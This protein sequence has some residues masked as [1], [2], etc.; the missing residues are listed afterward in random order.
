MIWGATFVLVKQALAG[1]STLL[2]LTLRFAIATLALALI[3]RKQFRNPGLSR[4]LRGGVIAGCFLFSGYVLQTFGLK[5]TSASK[6]GFITGLYIPL[7]PL[8]SSLVYKKIP[9]MAEIIGVLAAFSGMALMTVQKDLFDI[10]L[11]DLLVACCAVAYAFHILVLGRFAGSSE[12]RRPDSSAD[13]NLLLDLYGNVLVGG[14]GPRPMDRRPLD[15]PAG[16]RPICHG[17]GLRC[18]NLGAALQQPHAYGADLFHRAFIRMDNLLSGGRRSA[19]QA[20][21]SRRRADPG[22]IS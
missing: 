4:G 3:F 7:V 20:R 8:F 1:V 9:Q 2:F 18:S 14:A 5:Y 21:D 11:G 10:G 15:R 22:G 6:T 13:R 12:H 19:F 16:H 17:V